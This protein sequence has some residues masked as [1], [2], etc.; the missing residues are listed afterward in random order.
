[1]P[2]SVFLLHNSGLLSA[3]CTPQIA[4]ACGEYLN[5]YNFATAP[6][7]QVPAGTVA[8]F[9][10]HDRCFAYTDPPATVQSYVD[11]FD[12]ANGA[13]NVWG[14]FKGPIGMLRPSLE[15]KV[16]GRRWISGAGSSSFGA[17]NGQT[18]FWRNRSLVAL[19]Y[20][21]LLYRSCKHDRVPKKAQVGSLGGGGSACRGQSTA[22]RW[23]SLVSS[24]KITWALEGG[25]EL[26]RA[27]GVRHRGH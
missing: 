22:V 11:D 8:S 17:E 5:L 23:N 12:A 27:G 6:E 14:R 7:D 10:E 19:V 18:K 3:Q 15:R 9:L 21:K 20:V 1:M 4:A 25:L 16:S 26:V 2:Q 13:V 24:V